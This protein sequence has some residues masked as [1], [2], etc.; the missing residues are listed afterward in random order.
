[1]SSTLGVVNGSFSVSSSGP[2]ALDLAFSAH[3]SSELDQVAFL[4]GS[5]I[6]AIFV[7]AGPGQVNVY[8]TVTMNRLIGALVFSMA[9]TLYFDGS[10][11]ELAAN[12]SI[13]EVVTATLSP[14]LHMHTRTRVIDGVTVD[15]PSVESG[16]NPPPLATVRAVPNPIQPSTRIV[17]TLTHPAEGSI[18]V[19]SVAGRSVRTVAEGR[20]EAGAHEV[21]FDGRDDH[22]RKLPLGGYFL[23]FETDKVKVAGKLFVVNGG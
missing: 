16:T 15:V 8:G 17:Y 1:M 14:T 7:P 19:Y 10:Q 22:G 5:R 13:D 21:P 9:G 11:A 3:S 18:Q 20:F 6:Q 2:N 12:Q 4:P 23:R